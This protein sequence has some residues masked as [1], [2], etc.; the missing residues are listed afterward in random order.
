VRFSANHP[1]IAYI[2]RKDFFRLCALTCE[3]VTGPKMVELSTERFAIAAPFMRFLCEAAGVAY[4]R[5]EQQTFEYT[6]CLSRD[7]DGLIDLFTGLIHTNPPIYS[8][9]HT[10]P[11]FQ[12]FYHL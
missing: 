4:G 12:D 2:K 1:E 6:L 8:N 7:A 9:W 5:I 11:R 10:Y 3:E